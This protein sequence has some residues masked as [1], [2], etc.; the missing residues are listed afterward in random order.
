MS[1]EEFRTAFKGSPMKR[2]KLRGLKRNAAVVLG[3]VGSSDDV[4]SL[5]A[6]LADPEPLV[7]EHAGWALARIGQG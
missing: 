2:A 3:N 1:D 4:P 7:R 5:V 6:A